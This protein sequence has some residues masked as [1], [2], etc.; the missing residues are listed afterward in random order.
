MTSRDF[1]LITSALTPKLYDG[2][3]QE[4][5]TLGSWNDYLRH[6]S[7]DTLG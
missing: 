4:S 3:A 5:L 7:K 1:S 6:S 2:R